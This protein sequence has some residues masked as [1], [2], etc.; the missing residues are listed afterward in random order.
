MTE[1]DGLTVT[2]ESAKGLY[3]VEETVVKFS[4]ADKIFTV[5]AWAEEIED[6]AE[7]FNW[8]PAQKLLIARRSLVGA[9]AL[10]LKS[11]KTFKTYDDLKKALAKEFPDHVNVKEIHEMMASRKKKKDETCYEYMLVMKELGKRGGFADYVA[12]QYIVDG[13]EDTPSNKIMLYGVTTY[14]KLKDTLATYEMMKSKEKKPLSPKIRL[15]ATERA[16]VERNCY[17]CGEKNHMANSCR[18][19]IKCFKCDNFGHI[20]PH[21]P[22][23]NSNRARGESE[24]D[25]TGHR[26][27]RSLGESSEARV[28]SWQ[29]SRSR[30]MCVNSEQNAENM[31]ELRTEGATE[32]Q[33]G[34]PGCHQCQCCQNNR[35]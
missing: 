14:N 34:G 6:N 16:K 17:K 30:T 11:E 9:A 12:I 5:T 23:M 27:G 32:G 35:Q 33:N 8:T 31:N 4:G 21:C 15:R 1:K 22:A 13:I 29:Q 26:N 28:S 25:G 2:V 10:W 3:Q 24:G 7:I 18:N 20:A 19:G